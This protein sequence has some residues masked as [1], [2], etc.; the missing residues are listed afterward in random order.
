MLRTIS[1]S[2]LATV[3]LVAAA[4]LY[5]IGKE[6]APV[7]QA[8]APKQ[9]LAIGHPSME[10]P[11]ANPIARYNDRLFVANTP[12]GTLDVIDTKTRKILTRIPVG[13]DPVSVAVRPDGKEVWVSNHVSDSVSVID[14][15]P[16]SPTHLHVVATVQEFDA[17]TKA[18][19]FDEPVGIAFA[20][21]EKAYV[22]LSSENQIAVIDVASRK[23]T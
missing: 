13:I 12:A 6:D 21:N 18:T 14:T 20:G 11:H 16:S 15:D 23:I 10:S 4:T 5:A 8:D 2:L 17:N 1:A 19:K 3:M 7:R 9:P 22:A